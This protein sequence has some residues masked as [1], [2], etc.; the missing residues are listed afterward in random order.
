MALQK[1]WSHQGMT[2]PESY[3]VISK[4]ETR[5]NMVDRE[6]PVLAIAPQEDHQPKKENTRKVLGL[7]F[8]FGDTKTKP[9]GIMT[10][11]II[12]TLLYFQI[13]Q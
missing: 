4:L 11:R 2:F 8:L 12:S 3:W 13:T 9:V 7:G 10:Q 6:D 1:S 5:K